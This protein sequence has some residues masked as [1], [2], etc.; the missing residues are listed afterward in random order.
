MDHPRNLP[1]KTPTPIEA[2]IHEED[3]ERLDAALATMEPLERRIIVMKYGLNSGRVYSISQIAMAA[4]VEPQHVNPVIARAVKKLKAAYDRTPHDSTTPSGPESPRTS[5]T[6]TTSPSHGDSAT[7]SSQSR[8]SK[9]GS[10][11][12]KTP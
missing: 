4:K 2:M 12:P 1:A 3:R 11:S 9:S 5:T 7:E 10:A 6:P 8:K